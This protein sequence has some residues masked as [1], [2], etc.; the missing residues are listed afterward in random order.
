[1]VSVEKLE[2]LHLPLAVH[3]QLCV[4]AVDAHQD[5]GLLQ[6]AHVTARQ[7]V[8]DAF[9]EHLDTGWCCDNEGEDGYCDEV[10]NL[11]HGES[12][13]QRRDEEPDLPD[14]HM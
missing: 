9:R 6:R 8:G 7:T 14:R 5:T 1:M 11:F 12:T 2:H 3:V 4:P 10:Y 13:H